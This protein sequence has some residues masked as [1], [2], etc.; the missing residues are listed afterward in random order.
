MSVETK[1]ARAKFTDNID[2]DIDEEKLGQSVYFGPPTS[3]RK[4]Q[5]GLS[6]SAGGAPD[7]LSGSPILRHQ[8]V[9]EAFGDDLK[10]LNDVVFRQAGEN[11]VEPEELNADVDL[12][13]DTLSGR[14]T[15]TSSRAWLRE[16]ADAARDPLGED[17]TEPE[18]RSDRN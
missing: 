15:E 3:A 11:W 4:H 9:R 7:R 6:A 17:E 14:L 10:A 16:F 18:N 5:D 8:E 1:D 12:L 2:L 13:I